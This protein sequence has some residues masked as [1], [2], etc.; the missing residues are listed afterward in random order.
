MRK[1][2]KHKSKTNKLPK[3]VQQ[4]FN[5][6]ATKKTVKRRFVKLHDSRWGYK[7]KEYRDL[8]RYLWLYKWKII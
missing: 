4:Y 5:K 2:I 3:Y 8:K 1:K 7:T 6:N